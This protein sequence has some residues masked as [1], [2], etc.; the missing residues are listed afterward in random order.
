[1]G[2][3]PD[4]YSSESNEFFVSQCISKLGLKYTIVHY[5]CSIIMSKKCAYHNLKIL[6]K[7]ANDHLR[8]QQV[9][10]FG[11]WRV[12]TDLLTT[13]AGGS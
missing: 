6:L 8:F 10:F 4:H 7:T 12:D 9:V 2:L 11:W 13:Q 5:K 1:M 3:V